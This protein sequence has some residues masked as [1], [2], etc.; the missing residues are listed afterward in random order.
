MVVCYKL[1][2][3]LYSQGIKK[4]IYF[5]MISLIAQS[6]ILSSPHCPVNKGSK[7][8]KNKSQKREFTV[9]IIQ[10]VVTAPRLEL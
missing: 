5:F 3:D 9:L 8:P 6:N 1:L 2:I 4:N 10:S 7:S